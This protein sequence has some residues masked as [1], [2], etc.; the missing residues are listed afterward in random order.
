MFFEKR[1]ISDAKLSGQ[2]PHPTA[3]NKFKLLEQILKIW[4]MD[5]SNPHLM[6]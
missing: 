1:L 3:M 6:V 4:P 2:Q 5:K